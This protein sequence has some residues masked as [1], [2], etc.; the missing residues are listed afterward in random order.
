M[1]GIARPTWKVFHDQNLK[2][3]HD[4]RAAYA[5]HRYEQITAH[6]AP[7]NSGKCYL[8]DRRLDRKARVQISQEQE[9]GR[10]DVVAAYIGGRV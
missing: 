8:I 5:C 1:R 7:I 9:H 3:F 10:I 2:G 4:L 6:R